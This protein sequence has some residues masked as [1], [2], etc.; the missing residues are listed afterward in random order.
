MNNT[1]FALGTAQLGQIYGLKKRKK[2]YNLSESKKIFSFIRSNI[3]R[4]DLIDTAQLYGS[5]EEIIGRLQTN[6]LKIITKIKLKY[7]KLNI[8]NQIFNKVE[9]SLSNLKKNF[10]HG[11]LI[12]NPSIL[13]NNIGDEIYEALY[14]LKEKKLVKKVGLSIYDSSDLEFFLKNFKYDIIQ[15]PLNIVDQ[16]LKMQGWLKE[17]KKNKIEFHARSIFL[18][19]LLLLKKK[20]RKNFYIHNK[21]FWESWDNYLLVNKTK[22]I[23]LCLNFILNE[24]NIDRIIIGVNSIDELKYILQF[25]KS[26]LSQNINFNVNK[27]LIDPRKWHLQ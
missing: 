2:I 16:R 17:F 21:V 9:K 15:G 5:S 14:E 8:R 25:K 1:K 13:L 26:K 23:D 27:N 4:I 3:D 18:Q 20:E 22:P 11:L 10:I 19:G 6:D 24:K 7:S 12:H